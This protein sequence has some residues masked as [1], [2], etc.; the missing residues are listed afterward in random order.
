[1]RSW[2]VL[3]YDEVMNQQRKVIYAERR[4]I[5][6]G[7]NLKDRHGHGPRVITAYRRRRDRRRRMSWDLDALWTALNPLSGGD[8]R[9]LADPQGPRIRR[10][11]ALLKD[12]ERAYAAR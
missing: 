6:E 1:M 7:E 10:D 8:H 4:R 3:K 9:R 11:D 12:A 5:L 2:N